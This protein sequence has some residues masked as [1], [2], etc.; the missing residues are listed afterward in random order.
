MTLKIT[1][2]APSPTG[3]LHI[4]HAASAFFAADHGDKFILRLEDIDHTRCRPEFEQS[5]YEDMDWLGLDYARPVRRQSDHFDEYNSVLKKL[6]DMG[7]L[8]P[9]FCTRKDIEEEIYRSPSAPHGHDGFLYPRTCVQLSLS[10]REDRIASGEHYALRLD[11]TKAKKQVGDIFWCDQR[12]GKQIALPET[13]GDVVLARKDTPASYHL[14][15]THDDALQNINLV[16]RGEDLFHATHIHCLLQYILDLPTPDYYHHT[17][18]T[19]KNGKKFS[20]RDKSLTIREIRN[21]GF[22][23]S[24]LRDIIHSQNFLMLLNA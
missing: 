10:E 19:D 20:K 2:F 15:V 23:A 1:R 16:T 8:Y 17:L 12:K 11:V 5:I 3:Y 24:Q 18:L 14:C 22:A 7:L 13:L 6:S 9:C 21:K 4:G